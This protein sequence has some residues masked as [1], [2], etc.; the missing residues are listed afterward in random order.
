MKNTQEEIINTILENVKQ[1]IREPYTSPE[2]YPLFIIL[3]DSS[4]LCTQCARKHYKKIVRDTLY[5]MYNSG[6]KVDSTQINFENP[7]LYC[8][9]CNL[10]LDSAYGDPP[11]TIKKR[12]K[13]K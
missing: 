7:F 10:N 6:W 3:A 4:Y 9:E 8:D 12:S 13:L 5:S 11:K 2:R 1:A